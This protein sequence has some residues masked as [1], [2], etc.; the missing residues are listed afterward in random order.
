M[1]QSAISN[2]GARSR[3][4]D[5]RLWNDLWSALEEAEWFVSNDPFKLRDS[6]DSASWLSTFAEKIRE[7]RE[8]VLSMQE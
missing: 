3:Q 8:A 4:A 5:S 7:A 1:P 6:P 2:N